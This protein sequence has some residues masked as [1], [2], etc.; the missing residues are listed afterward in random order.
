[1][2]RLRVKIE[3]INNKLSIKTLAIANSGFIGVEPEILLPIE[4]SRQLEL[5]EIGEPEIHT[6]LLGDGRKLIS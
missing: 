4:L 2:L 1:M 3:V 5:H 6:K